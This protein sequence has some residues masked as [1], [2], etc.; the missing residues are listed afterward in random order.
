[1]SPLLQEGMDRYWH[2]ASIAGLIDGPLSRATGALA[3]SRGACARGVVR[4]GRLSQTCQRNSAAAR[5]FIAP[6]RR[7]SVYLHRP[8]RARFA[9][10]KMQ[11]LGRNTCV[12]VK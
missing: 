2:I 11:P 1:M 3:K 12:H 4:N 6:R 5:D 8:W 9:L 10:L 7:S